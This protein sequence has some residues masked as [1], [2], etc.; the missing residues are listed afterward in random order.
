[1]KFTVEVKMAPVG[2]ILREMGLEPDGDAQR[3]L[4]ET[5]SQRMTRYMPV[6]SGALSTDKKIV[7]G[8]DEITV[9]G[10][11]AHYQWKG[12]LM[13]DPVTGSAWAD[14]KHGPKVYKKPTK[15]LK[16]DKNKNPD[17]GPDWDSRLMD[18]EGEQI[19]RDLAEHIKR[20]YDGK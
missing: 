19:G 5:V 15:Y 14:P 9:L 4:T 18:A 11:Y 17:A 10:P 2:K 16:H 12:E 3:F 8:P 6:R 7:S 1:M 13:V 20:R